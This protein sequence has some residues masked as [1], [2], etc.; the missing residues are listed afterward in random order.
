[1]LPPRDRADFARF[2]AEA[3]EAA[4]LTWTLQPVEETLEQWRRIAVLSGSPG[5]AEA[6][7]H[8]RQVLGGDDVPAYDVDLEALG[9]GDAPAS[10]PTR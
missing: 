8:G 9:R 1:M 3:L 4:R 7:E 5:H 6:I 2:Y 10:W